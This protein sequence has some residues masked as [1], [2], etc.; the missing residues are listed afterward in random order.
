VFQYA[1]SCDVLPGRGRDA[2]YIAKHI[3][4]RQRDAVPVDAAEAWAAA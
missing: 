3:A 2:R 4:S 1:G